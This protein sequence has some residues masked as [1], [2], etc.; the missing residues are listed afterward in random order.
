MGAGRRASRGIP[1][2][3]RKGI[4]RKVGGRAARPALREA[5]QC[6]HQRR[7]FVPTHPAVT[8]RG[9][10]LPG[11]LASPAL[12]RTEALLQMQ[13]GLAL[14]LRAHHVASTL[15]C[16]PAGKG[17]APLAVSF[18]SAPSVSSLSIA[19]SRAWSATIR[20]SRPFS[21]SSSLRRLTVSS[22]A[23]P[24]CSLQRW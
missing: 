18:H 2:R 16:C 6:G 10:R 4:G 20:L 5:V 9:S 24:Y 11:H 8:L 13:D 12:A 21:F 19:L 23:P 1:P 3:R 14:A 15:R 22:L 17:A 7:V